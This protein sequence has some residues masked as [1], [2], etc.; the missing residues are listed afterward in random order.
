MFKGIIV[1]NGYYKSK[2]F[3]KKCQLDFPKAVHHKYEIVFVEN[4][5][6]IV[7]EIKLKR[8]SPNFKYSLH[9]V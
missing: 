1:P 6:N 2:K 7:P 8:N 3:G 4:G 5:S 9:F